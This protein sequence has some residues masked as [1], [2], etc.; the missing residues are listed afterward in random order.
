M[1]DNILDAMNRVNRM[2]SALHRIGGG[3]RLTVIGAMLGQLAMHVD[4]EQ[5]D[6]ALCTA[7]KGVMR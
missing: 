4:D 2:D 7:L 3:E 1:S 6:S 5:W